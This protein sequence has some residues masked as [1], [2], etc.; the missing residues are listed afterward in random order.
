MFAF[1][2]SGK[3]EKIKSACTACLASAYS[4]P[5]TEWSKPELVLPAAAVIRKDEELFHQV[6]RYRGKETGMLLLSSDLLR[7]LLEPGVS[8]LALTWA[9]DKRH[10]WCHC[11]GRCCPC[12]PLL[13]DNY[14][15][16]VIPLPNLAVLLCM[17]AADGDP[18]CVLVK[19]KELVWDFIR[20]SC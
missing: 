16:E 14:D 19:C 15:D 1:V 2:F 18:L 11:R 9:A 3:E 7:C 10:Y 4:R 6:H 8:G 20:K 12:F 17:V 5:S 13:N